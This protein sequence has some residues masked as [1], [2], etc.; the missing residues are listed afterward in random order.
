MLDL[1]KNVFLAPSCTN[2]TVI[3]GNVQK[4]LANYKVPKDKIKH[5]IDMDALNSEDYLI[6]Y[7]DGKIQVWKVE[8][9]L[10][11]GFTTK[12]VGKL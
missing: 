1:S 9:T 2:D 7:L 12:F 10:P 6:R 11:F 5:K 4:V 3:F 8:L